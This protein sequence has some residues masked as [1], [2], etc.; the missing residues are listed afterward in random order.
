MY[1]S[2]FWRAVEEAKAHHASSKTY[3]GKLMRPHWP[4]IMEE[5][6]KLQVCSILD[7]G[8]GKG[9]QYEW[10]VPEIGETLRK[11]FGCPIT[12]YDPAYPPFAS[13]PEGKFDYVICTHVLGSVPVQ[14]REAV[15]D[16]IYSYAMEGVYIA[17]KLGPVGKKVFTEAEE[18]THGQMTRDGWL[19]LLNRPSKRELSV[20]LSTRQVTKDGIITTRGYV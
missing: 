2:T 1:S 10:I 18:F 11:I 7:Y 20:T 3:S 13:K 16:E 4:F 19:A 5:V 17:E 15:V 6:Q 14:D 12:L 8:C 9:R